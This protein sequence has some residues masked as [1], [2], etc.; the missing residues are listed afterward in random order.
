MVIWEVDK[1]NAT[2]DQPKVFKLDLGK[3]DKK[4]KKFYDKHDK[5][6]QIL[7]GR[8]LELQSSKHFKDLPYWR[9]LTDVFDLTLVPEDKS[10]L[11]ACCNE[12]KCVI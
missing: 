3:H 12:R 9:L 2:P 7:I 11:R 8:I 1:T 5:T 6:R 4:L 10:N